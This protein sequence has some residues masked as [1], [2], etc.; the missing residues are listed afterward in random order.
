[1]ALRLLRALPGVSGLIATVAAQNRIA[2]LDPSVEGTGPH[3]LTVRIGALRQVRH[4]RPSHPAPRFVTIAKRLFGERETAR[5]KTRFT[6]YGNKNI[7]E[8][9]A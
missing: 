6:N 4:L 1:M 3:G 8:R 7:F 2:Q 9:C 5:L